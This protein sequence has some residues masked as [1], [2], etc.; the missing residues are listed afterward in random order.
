[1]ERLLDTA[2]AEM[3]IDRVELRRRNHIPEAT[4]PYK[5]PNGTTYDSC[6][7]TAVLNEALIH[8]DWGSSVSIQPP[9]AS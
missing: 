7:F 5:A 3:G 8:A 6:E 2:A 4:M 9:L 1:M